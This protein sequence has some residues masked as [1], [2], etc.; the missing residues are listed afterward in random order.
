[1]AWVRIES[2]MMCIIS[3]Y[4]N[5]KTIGD[6]KVKLHIWTM[7][8]AHL[9]C[10][11]PLPVL[12]KA[13]LHGHV[14]FSAGIYCIFWPIARALSVQKRSE[15]VKN[16]HAW[17]TVEDFRPI[18]CALSVQKKVLENMLLCIK[19]NFQL[20]LVCS[21]HSVALLNITL[22]KSN[23]FFIGLYIE[24]IAFKISFG[25]SSIPSSISE[26]VSSCT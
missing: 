6:L 11:N 26:N 19:H 22:F 13:L 9:E 20:K 15:I 7:V 23:K 5:D 1:M 10:I 4:M 16:E 3:L 17:Y 12:F 24:R 2:G 18:M 8:G 14:F 25:V 21:I